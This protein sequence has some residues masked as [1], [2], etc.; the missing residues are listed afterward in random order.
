MVAC[1]ITHRKDAI[2]S[3]VDAPSTFSGCHFPIKLATAIENSMFPK[4]K[5]C[6]VLTKDMD[7]E[8]VYL[9]TTLCWKKHNCRNH[10]KMKLFL[11]SSLALSFHS[12]TN[13]PASRRTSTSLPHHTLGTPFLRSQQKP[14]FFYCSPTCSR[15]S[16]LRTAF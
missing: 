2:E 9:S 3:L 14:K 7:Y 11:P 8:R 6:L 5:V 13:F 4:A 1:K 12:V 10:S 16:T 15:N